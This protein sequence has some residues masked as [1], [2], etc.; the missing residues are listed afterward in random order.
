MTPSASL[1]PMLGKP[2]KGKLPLGLWAV[3]P[4][5]D[6]TRAVWH[7]GQLTNRRGV[8]LANPP[9]VLAALRE[10][11]ADAS[12]DGELFGGDW[13]RTASNVRRDLPQAGSG[14]Q[15]WVFDLLWYKGKPLYGKAYSLR[16]ELLEELLI[17]RDCFGKDSPLQLVPSVPLG[18][19]DPHA[20]A[21]R[22]VES[23][24]EGAMLKNVNSPY[25]TSRTSSTEREIHSACWLK[26]K[27]LE[28][29]DATIVSAE[30]GHGKYERVLGALTVEDEKGRTYRVGGGFTEDERT[31]FWA[32]HQQGR[33]VGLRV[34]V[35]Y[36]PD[37]KI[38][39]RFNQFVRVRDD[40]T[41]EEA[42]FHRS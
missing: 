9:E 40:L 32:L 30:T 34:T 10:K 4:K 18:E 36:Q 8:A 6:G 37:E 21:A 22:L 13:N 19:A 25:V 38:K 41:P 15:F 5:L 33:L 17:L 31:Y 39:G 11:F 1:W 20:I 35:K 28:E 2:L 3:E 7:Q 42:A 29:V 26:L 23:G 27:L 16:R 12:L 14:V 24:Y